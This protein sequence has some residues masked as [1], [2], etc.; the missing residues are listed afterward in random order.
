M[1][2]TYPFDPTQGGE[3]KRDFEN[4]YYRLCRLS[5]RLFACYCGAP[6]SARPVF[7]APRIAEVTFEEPASKRY[8]ERAERY[9]SRPL[10]H[11]HE[12]PKPSFAV[13][14]KIDFDYG[15]P[16]LRT[17]DFRNY[18]LEAADR[19]CIEI[20]ERARYLFKCNHSVY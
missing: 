1:S 15:P 2:V 18:S 5:D 7:G 10:R 6:D 16:E 3:F 11:H 12:V 13:T 19:F 4:L 20:M 8:E 17:F 9:F 14:V